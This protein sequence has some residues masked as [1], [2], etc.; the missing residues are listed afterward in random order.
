ME[1]NRG[2]GCFYGNDII[3]L[4]IIILFILCLC[5]GI[6]GGFGGCGYKN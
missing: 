3:W 1:E 6:F 2:F 5:P 4:I